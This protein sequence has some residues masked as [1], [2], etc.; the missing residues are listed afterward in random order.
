MGRKNKSHAAAAK[1]VL[2]AVFVDVFL[3]EVL[4]WMSATYPNKNDVF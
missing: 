4:D 3:H 1:K 2:F